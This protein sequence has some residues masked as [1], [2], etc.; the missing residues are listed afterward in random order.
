[1]VLIGVAGDNCADAG[2]PPFVEIVKT[3][4]AV[5]LVEVNVADAGLK[6]QVI[7]AGRSAQPKVAVPV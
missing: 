4:A 1:M 6:L 3:V 7:S 5:A 2:E